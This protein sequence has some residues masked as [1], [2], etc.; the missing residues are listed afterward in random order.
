VVA[1]EK[2]AEPT[3]TLEPTPTEEPE[4]L[5]NVGGDILVLNPAAF[6][7]SS[8]GD[9]ES[10]LPLADIKVYLLHGGEEIAQTYTSLDGGFAFQEINETEDL[11]IKVELAHGIHPPGGTPYFQVVYDQQSDPISFS[12]QP[13]EIDPEASEWEI[14]SMRVEPMHELD[15]DPTQLTTNQLIDAALTYYYLRSSWH[16]A[17]LRLGQ[18]LDLPGITR[19]YNSR[20]ADAF[21]AGP[22]IWQELIHTKRTPTFL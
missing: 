5:V 9:F 16:F 11:V 19:I 2:P 6:L 13:F 22:I 15:M 7:S 18:P 12:T 1:D 8:P 21:W 14:I 4:V 17:A 20:E 3:P 10:Y